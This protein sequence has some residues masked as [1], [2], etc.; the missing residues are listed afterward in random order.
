MPISKMTQ[1][2][3]LCDCIKKLNLINTELNCIQNVKCTNV[4][5]SLLFYELQ[6]IHVENY[7]ETRDK[8]G[9]V[10]W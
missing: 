5:G 3:V 2:E 9:N 6:I 10:S 8:M 1:N 7:K 4:H